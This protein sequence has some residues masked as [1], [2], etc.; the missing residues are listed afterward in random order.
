MKEKSVYF[1]NLNSLRFIAALL[2]IVHHVEQIRMMFGMENSFENKTIELI[3]RMG[4]VLF[5][6]LSG[7][8]I[9]YL[10]L[11]EKEFTGEINIKNFY[12]RRVLRIWPL[13]F[14]IIILALFIMPEFHF[15]TFPDYEKAVVRGKLA[16]KINTF[17]GPVA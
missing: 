5:F 3:G 11:A 9:S 7:F 16:E 13:Y 1:P 14:F 17:C 4:V 15:F 12:I 6:V 10:L 2:V 8:L